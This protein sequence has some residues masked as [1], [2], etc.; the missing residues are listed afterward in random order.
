LRAKRGLTD[1]DKRPVGNS[2]I[3]VQNARLSGPNIGR[4]A[5]TA[6]ADE[7][8]FED[9]RFADD[10]E[11]P[12]IEGN[13]EKNREILKRIRKEQLSANVFDTRDEEAY[14]EEEREQRRFHQLR[15]KQGKKVTKEARKQLYLRK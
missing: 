10:E 8:D 11:T 14:E 6:E 7:L 12:I 15:K 1:I 5:E 4:K 13:E 3:Q 9:D 2:D